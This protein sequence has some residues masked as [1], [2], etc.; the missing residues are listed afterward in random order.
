M[1]V[2]LL[3]PALEGSRPKAD[4]ENRWEVADRST[5]PEPERERHSVAA[6]A[7]SPPG[8]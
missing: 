1:R 6:K 8:R 7:P 4:Y 2:P 3:M 5:E